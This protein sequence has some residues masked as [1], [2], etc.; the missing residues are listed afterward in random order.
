MHSSPQAQPNGQS[1]SHILARAGIQPVAQAQP[2][3]A[4]ESVNAQV[5]ERSAIHSLV[6]ASI[7][8]AAP[9]QPLLPPPSAPPTAKEI[10]EAPWKYGRGP[11]TYL[12]IQMSH[13]EPESIY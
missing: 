2:L 6:H 1:A 9:A 5:H 11:N 10:A 12:Q 4:E 8:G 3:L 7:P 13:S